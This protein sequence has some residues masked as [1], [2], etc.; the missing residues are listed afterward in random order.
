[1]PCDQEQA[2]Q[3]VDKRPHQLWMIADAVPS[4]NTR[5]TQTLKH[6]TASMHPRWP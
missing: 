4:G 2:D 3:P 5:P 1:V 6:V